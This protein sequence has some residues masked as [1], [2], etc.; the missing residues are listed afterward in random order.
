MVAGALEVLMAP[1]KQIEPK[2]TVYRGVTFDS[3]LEARW[4]IIFD[5]CPNILHF[6][7][8]PI[9][10]TLSNGWQYTPDFQVTYC[11][12][13]RKPCKLYVEIKPDQ[14]ND[15]YFRFLRQV[16]EEVRDE[17]LLVF[18]SV[19]KDQLI[20][21]S[22]ISKGRLGVGVHPLELFTDYDRAYE[23]ACSYRFDL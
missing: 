23:I 11:P 22:L 16:T 15:D 13:N 6:T 17:I 5:N 10:W 20:G 8:H 7:Y 1:R 2:P 19:F 4:A 3:R 14:P 9:T 12:L 18:G 21:G